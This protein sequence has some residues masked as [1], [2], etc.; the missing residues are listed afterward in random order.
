MLPTLQPSLFVLWMSHHIPLEPLHALTSP[1]LSMS[2]SISRTSSR[3]DKMTFSAPIVSPSLSPSYIC[4]SDICLTMLTTY[5]SCGV[6]RRD[7]STIKDKVDCLWIS[8][9]SIAE[10]IHQFL[11]LR[12]L[13]QFEEDLI[14]EMSDRYFEIFVFQNL[15]MGC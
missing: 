3:D 10:G 4:Q 6:L 5:R 7:W 15:R 2:A 11:E 1:G 12:V 9:L 14:G 8:A 13:L